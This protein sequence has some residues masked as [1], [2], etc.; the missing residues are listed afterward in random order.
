MVSRSFR[1]VVTTVLVAVF[2][3]TSKPFEKA[4]LVSERLYS[5]SV[6]RRHATMLMQ[7]LANRVLIG[8]SLWLAYTEFGVAVFRTN[9][10]SSSSGLSLFQG[11][12]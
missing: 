8:L 11:T 12:G 2:Y 4:V 3:V 6:A 5:D 10:F 9:I 7:G 1:R